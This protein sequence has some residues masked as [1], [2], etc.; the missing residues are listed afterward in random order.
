MHLDVALNLENLKICKENQMN[1]YFY[2]KNELKFIET[3][4][5]TLVKKLL[6]KSG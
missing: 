6:V 4:N 3:A 2:L 5:K 1:C